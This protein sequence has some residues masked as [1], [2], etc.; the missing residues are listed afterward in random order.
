MFECFDDGEA[1]AALLDAAAD[2]LRRR[3]RST[4]MGPIDYSTNYP[5]GLL[6][7]G[8][9]MPPRVMMNHHRPYYAGLLESWGLTKIKDLYAWWFVDPRNMLAKWRRKA[10]RLAKRGG[11]TVRPF[12]KKNFAA[13]AEG[14]Q[15]IYNQSMSRNWGFVKLTAAEFHHFAKRLT[16]I[17]VPELV[18]LAEVDRKP[19]GCSI[20]LPDFNEAIRP[21]NGRLTTFGL[22][23]GLTRLMRRLPRVKTA[24]MV[25]L[26][27]LEK[28]RRRGIAE[29]LILQTLDYGKNTLG[30][31]GAE[32]S[33]TDEDNDLVNRTIQ[34]VGGRRYKTYRIYEKP[35]DSL[36]PGLAAPA[37]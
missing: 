32:L 35:I 17:T 34:A 31:T 5:C 11:V 29:L 30:Y 26:N 14:L 25:I 8:F 36:Q 33:W 18:F 24:R 3:G 10:E 27:V 22:P 1:A 7:D 19:V 12:R 4:V 15:E 21:L 9:Y 16:Q 20:T 6:V 13:D 2:W 28:Y 23:I 37:G